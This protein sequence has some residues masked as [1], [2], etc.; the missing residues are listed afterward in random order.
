ME[1]TK[2]EGGG[3]GR[4]WQECQAEGGD[5][6]LLDRGRRLGLSK[7]RQPDTQRSRRQWWSPGMRPGVLGGGGP[8]ELA[9]G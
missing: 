9:E 8:Q 4:L 6:G 3:A 7:K 5:T 1:G 2:R